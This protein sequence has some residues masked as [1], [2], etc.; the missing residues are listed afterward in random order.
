M[1]TRSIHKDDPQALGMPRAARRSL[2]LCQVPTCARE[3][4]AAHLMCREHWF[5]VPAELRC[6]V[7]QSLEA[8]LKR[9]VELNVYLCAR[10]EA[11]AHVGKLHSIDVSAQETELA[12]RLDQL[13]E[14]SNATKKEDFTD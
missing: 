1:I 8:W 13:K 11:I 10:L 12:R 9:R 14:K 2:R 3:V 4:P 7:E 5:E 6:Q